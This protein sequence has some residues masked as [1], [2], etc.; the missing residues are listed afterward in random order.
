MHELHADGMQANFGMQLTSNRGPGLVVCSTTRRWQCVWR[1]QRCG[2]SQLMPKSLAGRENVAED[3]LDRFS[4]KHLADRYAAELTAQFQTL[5]LFAQRAGEIG[6]THEVFLRTVLERFLPR[7]LRCGT[8][9][10]ASADGVSRQQ[11]VIVFDPGVLPL[12]F[13]VGDCLVVDASAVAG[14]IEVKTCLD[15]TS[16]FH[17]ALRQV[18]DTR[19]P[20]GFS[21]LYAWD[22]L[23]LDTLLEHLWGQYRA[24]RDLATTIVP[25]VIYVRV[26][27]LLFPN[28]DGRRRTPPLQVLRVDGRTRTEG[29]ALLTFVSQMW[30]SGLQHKAR[31]PWWVSECTSAPLRSASSSTGRMTCRHKRIAKTQIP[32]DYN[33]YEASPRSRDQCPF[34]PISYPTRPRGFRCQPGGT[35]RSTYSPFTPS[36]SI[37]MTTG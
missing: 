36:C 12:L 35:L 34:A 28:Y 23:T 6:R 11:D 33:S 3:N 20:A 24:A 15:S 9:S 22:G 37:S 29:E 17:E 5:N 13:E 2:C 14:T 10:V 16:T 8:G 18:V 1:H 21:A 25:S 19:V 26:R 4:M 27:Y 7:S 32:A 31:W 30:I